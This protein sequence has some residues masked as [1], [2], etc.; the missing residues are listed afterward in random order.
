MLNEGLRSKAGILTFCQDRHIHSRDFWCNKILANEE[1]HNLIISPNLPQYVIQERVGICPSL[2]S[3]TVGFAFD[4]MSCDCVYFQ[5]Q[6]CPL[7]FG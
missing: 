6:L 3:C 2:G 7:N 5:Q 1:D 4:L